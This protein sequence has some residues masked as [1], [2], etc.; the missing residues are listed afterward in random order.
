MTPRCL[1]PCR[2]IACLFLLAGCALPEPGAVAPASAMTP[3]AR[4]EPDSAASREYRL[5]VSPSDTDAR[6]FTTAGAT[7][8]DQLYATF[9]ATCHGVDGRGDGRAAPFSRVPPTD[10]TRA[11]FKVRSTRFGALPTDGDI[12][13]V[14]LKGAGGDGV[15]PSFRFLAAEERRALVRKVKS[16]SQRWTFERPPP[17]V[18]LPPRLTGN[19]RRGAQIYRNWGCDTCHGPGGAGDGPRAGSLRHARG[20]EEVP[21][22][23]TRP[24]TLKAGATESALL[25]SIVTGLSGTSMSSYAPPTYNGSDLWDLVAHVRSLQRPPPEPAG[26]SGDTSTAT[27]YWRPPLRAG[28]D[29]VAAATC[30]TCH[31]LQFADWSRSRHAMTLS[32]GLWA[33]MQE[34]DGGGDCLR[35]HAP[36]AEQAD[37]A[38][39]RA[40]GVTCAACHVRAGETFGPAPAPGTLLPLVSGAGPVHGRVQTRPFFE[41]SQFCAGCHHFQD[42]AAPLVAGTTLQNTYEEWRNSRAAREGR[43]CQTCHM[44]DRRHFFRGIHDPET[45]RRAVRWTFDAEPRG[46]DVKARMTLTNIGAGHY[47]PTYVVPEI[48]MRIEVKDGG[49]ATLAFAEHRIARKVKFE[50]GEWTQTSDT[51]LAPDQ[52]A[53]LEYSGV[54][55]RDAVSIVGRVVVLP[56][57]WQADKFRVRLAA[58]QSETVRR[59]YRAA[60]EE[61]GSSGY[62]LFHAEQPLGR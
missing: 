36:L 33:Q 19:A 51:R 16:F 55:P 22:D 8:D 14:I 12:E 57:L 43:T 27:A 62:T 53:A 2:W 32:P 45:V 1:L 10:F 7:R 58:A 59:Y 46:R 56:D 13:N 40:D 42:G 4:G 52:T 31:P 60:L 47:L 48:W 21:A 9:C 29:R 5:G 61:A 50:N 20:F 38:Y 3:A 54:I 6:E 17:P 34:R 26:V 25:R 35:C 15:M 24:S 28:H 11:E 18:A 30:A 37:D 44:P 23:L 41:Q 39:L 49:G